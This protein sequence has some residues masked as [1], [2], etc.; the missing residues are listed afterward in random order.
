MALAAIAVPEMLKVNAVGLA[1]I[2]ITAAVAD[3]LAVAVGGDEEVHPH[4]AHAGQTIGRTQ[5]RGVHGV[6]DDL[7]GG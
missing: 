6:G 5:D 4:D 1:H 2:D 7:R 3:V